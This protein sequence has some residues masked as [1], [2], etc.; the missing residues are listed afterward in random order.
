M[1]T[2]AEL[3]NALALSNALAT[4]TWLPAGAFAQVAVYGLDVSLPISADPA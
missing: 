2:G 1:S 4:S 3:V